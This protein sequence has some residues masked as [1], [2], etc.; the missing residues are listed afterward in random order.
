ME[1]KE[2]AFGIYHEGFYEEFVFS[3]EEEKGCFWKVVPDISFRYGDDNYYRYGLVG[4][5][6]VYDVFCFRIEY[7]DKVYYLVYERYYWPCSGCDMDKYIEAEFEIENKT[8][9]FGSYGEYR[10]WLYIMNE[11]EYSEFLERTLER[12]SY[13]YEEEED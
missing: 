7:R 4:Q 11:S 10:D 6:D 2:F 12:P 1:V 13:E 5:P 8:F 9:I 3:T